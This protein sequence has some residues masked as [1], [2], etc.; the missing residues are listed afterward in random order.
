MH[1]SRLPLQLQLQGLTLFFQVLPDFQA[2]SLQPLLILKSTLERFRRAFGSAVVDD[3][4]DEIKNHQIVFWKL[5]W[6]GPPLSYFFLQVNVHE[7]KI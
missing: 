3:M 6:A 2:F 1:D 4:A 5:K 7:E